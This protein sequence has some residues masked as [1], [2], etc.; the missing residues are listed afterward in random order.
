[1]PS[2]ARDDT[3]LRYWCTLIVRVSM[4]TLHASKEPRF[5]P[6]MAASLMPPIASTPLRRYSEARSSCGIPN[7]TAATGFRR[8]SNYC[9]IMSLVRCLVSAVAIARTTALPAAIAVTVP[10]ALTVAAVG[11]ADR[12]VTVSGGVA[13]LARVTVATSVSVS[14]TLNALEAGAT[15]TRSTP[16]PGGTP[17]LSRSA[18][19]NSTRGSTAIGSPFTDVV[20]SRW[21]CGWPASP[22][23]LAG[24]WTTWW[25]T[26]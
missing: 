26:R 8:L 17:V 14:P 18:Q 15:V 24:A 23:G 6:D 21:V 4:R 16:G 12:H 10:V 7:C 2:D 19:A 9:A 11:L 25:P 20:A 22:R 5:D 13:P 3:V 1:M